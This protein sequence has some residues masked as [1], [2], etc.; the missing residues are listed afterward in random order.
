MT[1]PLTVREAAAA[2]SLSQATIRGWIA[3]EKIGVIRLGRA[4]RVPMAEIARLLDD[5]YRP[6]SDYWRRGVA[7]PNTGVFVADHSASAFTVRAVEPTPIRVVFEQE[8]P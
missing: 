1:P 2:L 7:V 8:K 4:V 6:A 3:V 5:G